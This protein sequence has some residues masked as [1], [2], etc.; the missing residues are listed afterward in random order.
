[1]S[2]TRRKAKFRYKNAKNVEGI[3]LSSLGDGPPIFR[4]YGKK[5]EFKDYEIRHH[6]VNVRILDD[7][8][9]LLE[10]VDGE[11]FYLDYSRKVLGQ[12]AK[13]K[14]IKK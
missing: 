14:R 12:E 6:D 13:Y 9:E 7:S 8:A 3:L 2:S 11:Q 1:M 4:I 5:G 10:S